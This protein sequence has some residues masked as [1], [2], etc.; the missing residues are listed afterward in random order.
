MKV[1][2]RGKFHQYSIFCC[3]VKNVKVFPTKSAS[4][5][6]LFFGSLLPQIWYDCAGI[7]ARGNIVEE[8]NM[9]EKL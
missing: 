3:Q 7:R 2:N 5:L 4:M 9:F 6:G 8:I 1:H